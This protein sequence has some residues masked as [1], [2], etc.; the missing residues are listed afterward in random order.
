M[1]IYYRHKTPI[2]LVK[3]LENCMWKEIG[4]LHTIQKNLQIICLDLL[5]SLVKKTIHINISLKCDTCNVSWQINMN[6]NQEEW[7]ETVTT[8]MNHLEKIDNNPLDEMFNFR[9]FDI[10]IIICKNEIMTVF[11]IPCCSAW[12]EYCVFSYKNS[13]GKRRRKKKKPNQANFDLMWHGIVSSQVE[14]SILGWYCVGWWWLALDY[15]VAN[16]F[17]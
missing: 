8:H 17:P 3:I 7:R 2:D 5:V 6:Q 12:T 9:L 16:D 1:F 10:T 4:I 13:L 14:G 11:L 15:T